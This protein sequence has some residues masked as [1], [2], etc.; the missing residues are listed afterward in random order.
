MAI[1]TARFKAEASNDVIGKVEDMASDANAK[2]RDMTENA[3]REISSIVA[4]LKTQLRDL[5]VDTEKVI[6]GAKDSAASVEKRIA[7]EI[8]ARPVRSLALAAGVGLLLGFLSR[9]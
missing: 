8:V 2:A 5:G 3:V 7:E 1:N 4:S 9:K 6:D